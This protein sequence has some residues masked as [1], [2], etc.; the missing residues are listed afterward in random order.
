MANFVLYCEILYADSQSVK[1]MLLFAYYRVK[2]EQKIDLMFQLNFNFE[3]N[4]LDTELEG[5]HK[6]FLQLLDHR[7]C[8]L[9]RTYEFTCEVLYE[10]FSCFVCEI[11][12]ELIF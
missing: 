8:G 9:I 11:V 10:T 1:L 12:I 3:L 6:I 2:T 7:R 4:V 5:I